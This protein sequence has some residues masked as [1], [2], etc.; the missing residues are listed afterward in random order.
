MAIQSVIALGFISLSACTAALLG[1]RRFTGRLGWIV[2][3]ALVLL[4]GGLALWF[5]PDWAG[6]LTAIFFALLVALPL[7]LLG[8]SKLAAQRGQ[9]KRAAR[10][11]RWAAYFHPSPWTRFG[12]IVRTHGPT[13]YAA[14]LTQ[15][16]SSGSRKQRALARVMLAHERRDWSGLLILSR[17]GD[18]PCA[19]AKP[20]EI[21][22][23]GE[24]G[25]LDEMV[26]IYQ[27]AAR[28]L[29]L[30][31]L[32]ECT[33]F[34]LA[35]TGR[36]EGVQQMLDRPF[37]TIDD[38]SKTYWTGVARLRRDIHDEAGRSMLRRLTETDTPEGVR[39]SAAQQLQQ[40]DREPGLSLSLT[41]DSARAIDAMRPVDGWPDQLQ[42][43]VKRTR[44][45]R[46]RAA[47]LLILLFMIWAALQTYYGW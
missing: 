17:A 7:A 33:L 47:L 39:R 41:G 38:A 9:W 32:R 42:Q 37:L 15:I 3:N 12:A 14:A 31:N 18:V 36:V 2:A 27:K 44:K 28:W 5:A 13:E 20:R 45:A 8:Q 35:F 11:H 1:S 29:P 4:G 34:V 19:E 21:R 10:L 23:L 46:F 22:A 16:E 25:R 24:L 26:Q 40:A 6:W 43:W 30:D